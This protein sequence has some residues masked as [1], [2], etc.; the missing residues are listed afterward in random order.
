[1]DYGNE[2]SLYKLRT[3]A[4]GDYISP[5][6]EF[7]TARII[8][9]E[10]YGGVRAHSG[11]HGVVRSGNWQLLA[12][13]ANYKAIL[14]EVKAEGKPA[15]EGFINQIYFFSNESLSWEGL[16]NGNTYYLCVQLIETVDTSTRLHKKVL[17]I[18]NN[19]GLI[20]D[21]AV[22]IAVMYLNE[23]GSTLVDKNP[24]G[25]INI[26]ILGD[27]IADNKDPHGAI[28]NQSFV[29][30]SGVSTLGY[31][32]YRALEVDNLL[33]SGN[34]LISGNL[35]VLGNFTISGD[36][37]LFGNIA[38]NEI[39][40]QQLKCDSLITGN[41]QVNSG[42][43]CF[44]P[45]LFRQNIQLASGVT[46]DG[47]DPSVGVGLIDG[48]NADA[49]HTHVLGSLGV[50]LKIINLSP[51]YGNTVLSG[52]AISGVYGIFVPARVYDDNMYDWYPRNVS[53]TAAFTQT[54]IRLPMD[55]DR[56]DRVMV[57]HGVGNL[58]SG[59]NINL[60]IFDKDNTPLI[61]TSPDPSQL[62]SSGIT[63]TTL[64]FSGGNLVAGQPMTI[65]SRLWGF[66]GI[67]TYLGDINVW[68][69]PTLGERIQ[70][71]WSQAGAVE[72]PEANWDALRTTPYSL[73]VDKVIATQGI[74]L[75]GVS[76]FSLN[77]GGIGETPVNLLS[78]DEKP[79]ISFNDS[80]ASFQTDTKTL[81]N[82]S[83]P[84]NN[85][86]SVSIDSIA[87]GSED[88]SVQLIAYR[89]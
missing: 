20:P 30:S 56:L 71:E 46:I 62:A 19:T 82:I 35:T 23:P 43:D 4:L 73:R 55:F 77:I 74:G 8:E 31:L 11:G 41:L 59:N 45:S 47:F 28:L 25:R 13:D 66:S 38:Y 2:T 67:H 9:N 39:V 21:D 26:P 63:D 69:V 57:R 76:V 34:G 83:I 60:S 37:I 68:Y 14:N 16:V 17:P 51:E 65:I 15:V 84:A 79:L 58:L 88:V 64:Y 44:A 10:L 70:F 42:L 3:P 81:Y 1:M 40:T 87:S 54:K 85:I 22:L 24:L 18:A 29:V 53:G 86:I 78:A 49:L 12:D 52:G 5:S 61:I 32:Y 50:N 6:E 7:R 27:H 75:S 36:V 48:S 72:F 33:I 80:G 89:V